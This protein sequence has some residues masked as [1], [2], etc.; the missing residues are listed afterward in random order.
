MDPTHFPSHG[1]PPIPPPPLPPTDLATTI[2][3]LKSLLSFASSTLSSL[4]F[5]SPPLHSPSLLPCPFNPHHSLPPESLYRHFLTCPSPL[6]PLPSIPPPKPHSETQT[7]FPPT[8]SDSD[9]DA[10]FI[11]SLE[12]QIGDLGSMFVY[13]DCPGVVSSVP[14]LAKSFALP[15][16]LLSECGTLANGENDASSCKFASILPSEYWVLRSEVEAWQSFPVSYSYTTLRAILGFTTVSEGDLKKWIIS[17]SPKYGIVIDVAIR[18]H[19][20]FLLKVCLKAVMKEALCSLDTFL[21]NDGVS[22]PKFLISC[23]KFAGSFSWLS[24]QLSILYGEVYARSF[25]LGM[26]KEAIIRSGCCILMSKFDERDEETDIRKSG[27]VA[28]EGVCNGS[29][30]VSDVACAIGALH[31]RAFLEQNIRALRSSQSVPKYQ[32]LMEYAY[33]SSRAADERS[34]RPNYRPISDH[35]SLPSNRGQNQENGGSKTKEELLAEERDYKRRRTS[36]RGKKVKRSPTEV[37]RD[38]IEEHMD[39]IK[40]AGGIWSHQTSAENTSSKPDDSQKSSALDSYSFYK[41]PSPNRENSYKRSKYER[42]DTADTYYSR[43]YK[44]SDDWHTGKEKRRDDT[45]YY[46]SRSYSEHE[47]RYKRKDKGGDH[48]SRRNDIYEDRE[49]K[50]RHH[51]YDGRR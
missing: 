6:P 32:R 47:G 27:E 8:C 24:N 12:S 48:H 17:N 28:P 1:F 21:R 7:S 15:G 30:L 34:K 20:W 10:D 29:V 23:P 35:D 43:S 9:S 25:S 38:I 3:Q 16:F 19:I 22:D 51:R 41:S 5:P 11:F 37:L 2:S 13:K 44:E 26:I 31:Q 45:D 46:S 40:Q 42:E 50:R 14:E 33:L 4:P 49:E 36:Y 18:D 39:V